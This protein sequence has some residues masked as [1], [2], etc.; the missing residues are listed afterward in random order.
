MPKLIDDLVSDG[1]RLLT[2]AFAPALKCAPIWRRRI[3]DVLLALVKGKP[4]GAAAELI[5]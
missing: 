4:A 1:S 5:D 2:A 3:R